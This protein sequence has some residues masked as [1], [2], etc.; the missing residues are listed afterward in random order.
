MSKKFLLIIF[1]FSSFCFS[2]DVD[3]LFAIGNNHY[4]DKNFSDSIKYY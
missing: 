4:N 2:Q 1:I 3:S